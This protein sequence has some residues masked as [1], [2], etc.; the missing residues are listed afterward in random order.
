MSNTLSV[1]HIGL[2]CAPRPP[3]TQFRNPHAQPHTDTHSHTN[4]GRRIDTSLKNVVPR[5]RPATIATTTTATTT[6]INKMHVRKKK[7][8]LIETSD[9]NVFLLSIKFNMIEKFSRYFQFSPCLTVPIR[10]AAPRKMVCVERN[11][12]PICLI[13]SWRYCSAMCKETT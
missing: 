6:K 11:R 10:S 5:E 12:R 2:F 4:R 7:K 3:S 8:I 1:F 9:H 13:N